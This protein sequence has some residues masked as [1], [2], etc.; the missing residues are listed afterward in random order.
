MHKGHITDDSIVRHRMPREQINRQRKFDECNFYRKKTIPVRS[1]TL[2]N[3]F[4]PRNKV[5]LF[6]IV[7]G[8]RNRR[9]RSFHMNLLH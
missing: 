5:N 9:R 2:S 1:F 8:S 4:L 6:R 7:F 3:P